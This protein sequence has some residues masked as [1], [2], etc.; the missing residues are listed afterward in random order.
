M[1]VQTYADLRG[2]PVS[3]HWDDDPSLPECT[4]FSDDPGFGSE[5]EAE[6]ALETTGDDPPT[7]EMGPRDVVMNVYLAAADHRDFVLKHGCGNSLD[8]AC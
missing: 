7:C 2:E 3:Q 8:E 5:A 1:S 6:A 4:D